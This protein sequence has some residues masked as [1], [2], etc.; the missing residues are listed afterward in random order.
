M[1]DGL[2]PDLVQLRSTPPIRALVLGLLCTPLYGRK[3]EDHSPYVL[4]I[5]V[6]G[7]LHFRPKWHNIVVVVLTL[8]GII[9]PVVT[10]QAPVIHEWRNTPRGNKT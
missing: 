2:P 1:G 4:V 8:T 9:K 10:G 5:L 6:E 7:F 3:N